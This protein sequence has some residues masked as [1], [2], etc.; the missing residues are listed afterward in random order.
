MRR[1][2]FVYM[3]PGTAHIFVG[4]G[5]GPCVMVM[6]SNRDS[7]EAIL[8]PVS[9]VAARHGASAERETDDPAVAYASSSPRLPASIGAVP[10]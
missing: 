7:D 8:Y 4:A 1:G 5:D 10:W 2:D 9:E 3:P 6:V